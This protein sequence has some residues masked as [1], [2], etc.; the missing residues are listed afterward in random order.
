MAGALEPLGFEVQSLT[1]YLGRFSGGRSQNHRTNI[2]AGTENGAS[3][4]QSSSNILP[5][6][7]LGGQVTSA[8]RLSESH[9]RAAA[10]DGL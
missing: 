1:F 7:I 9:L 10:R 3:T 8:K 4:N 2:K 5:R 6:P